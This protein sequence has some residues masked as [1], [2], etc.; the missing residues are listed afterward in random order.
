MHTPSDGLIFGI[1]P[2]GAT[3]TEEG[4]ATQGPAEN[5]ECILRALDQLQGTKPFIVRAYELYTDGPDV[6]IQARPTPEHPLQYLQNGRRLD[7]V[8]MFQSLSGNVAGY[9]EF[10]RQMVRQYGPHCDTMQITE[11]AN[12]QH[13]GLD[14]E[15]P[16]AVDARR[17]SV[18][19]AKGCNT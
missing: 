3:G 16:N 6:R 19:S 14:G 15:R 1:Y 13:S 12:L 11:E 9:C 17:P 4:Q 18:W 2:G 5:P 8:V 10:V 7:L